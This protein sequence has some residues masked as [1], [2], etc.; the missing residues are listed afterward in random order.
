MGDAS[1]EYILVKGNFLDKRID[2]IP[3]LAP[4]SKITSSG[5]KSTANNDLYVDISCW[6]KP[7]VCSVDWHVKVKV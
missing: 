1:K 7:I 5:W 4:K 3:K 2:I 6:I